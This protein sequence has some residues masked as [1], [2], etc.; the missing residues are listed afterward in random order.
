MGTLV[1]KRHH[2]EAGT[3]SSPKDRDSPT[4]S[5]GGPKHPARE[6]DV[7]IPLLG[8][9]CGKTS[10]PRHRSGMGDD[11]VSLFHSSPVEMVHQGLRSFFL[12][13]T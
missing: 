6:G 3:Y 10:S 12:S 13:I 5:R 11:D 2:L 9:G 4:A 1:S 8:L 7:L